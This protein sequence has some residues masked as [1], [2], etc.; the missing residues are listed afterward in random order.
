MKRQHDSHPCFLTTH[1]NLSNLVLTHIASATDVAIMVEFLA[2]CAIFGVS[3]AGLSNRFCFGN[4]NLD[5]DALFE[6]VERSI[7]AFLVF[8]LAITL[9][10]VRANFS[11]AED[12]VVSEALEVR[13]YLHVLD[14]QTG[15][16]TDEQKSHLNTYLKA[17]VD[18]EWHSLAQA[19]PHLSVPAEQ[20]I[21]GLRKS[22]QTNVQASG[23]TSYTD[24]ILSSL[25]KLENSRLLRYQLAT[26]SSPRIFWLYIA[27]LMV[28]GCVTAGRT[29]LDRR[30]AG[31]LAAYFGALGMV[32]GLIM[33]LDQPFRGE[34]SISSEPFRLV[35]SQML[36]GS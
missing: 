16:F 31:V 20:A 24:R 32:V 17:V 28:L 9:G 6:M 35:L 34:T 36:A 33:I 7:F 19:Q 21:L 5:S 14:L 30:R 3:I 26:A 22:V 25:T 29:K 15:S 1:M 13:Q 12:S 23:M 11:K 4:Q 8:L 10:D 2:F 27:V 18:D